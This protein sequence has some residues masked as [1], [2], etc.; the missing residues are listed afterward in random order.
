MHQYITLYIFWVNGYNHFWAEHGRHLVWAWKL[1]QLGHTTSHSN[2]LKLFH[3]FFRD[4]TKGS[5]SHMGMSTPQIL[6]L[7]L[8]ISQYLELGWLFKPCQCQWNFAVWPQ[9]MTFPIC[10]YESGVYNPLISLTF[11]SL[12]L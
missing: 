4:S 9:T 11:W 2:T 6:Q 10:V 7:I 1:R 12:N 8:L 5:T 3:T